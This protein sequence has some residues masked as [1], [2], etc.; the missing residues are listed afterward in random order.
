MPGPETRPRANI[1]E[2]C[3]AH[4]RGLCRSMVVGEELRLDRRMLE[5]AYPAHIYDSLFTHGTAIDKLMAGLIGSNWRY[6]VLEDPIRGDI[7]IRRMAETDKRWNVDPDRR[8]RF[9]QKPDGS[10]EPRYAKAE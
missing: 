3:A 6:R 5:D 1:Q 2:E 9:K 4:L 7:T 10:W 8:D